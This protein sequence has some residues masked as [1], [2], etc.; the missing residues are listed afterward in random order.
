M[1]KTTLRSPI[2]PGTT[3]L[4]GLSRP[5]R[6]KKSDSVKYPTL[7]TCDTD[8]LTRNYHVVGNSRGI[9][10]IS[11]N[12]RHTIAGTSASRT[13]RTVSTTRP[14]VIVDVTTCVTTCNRKEQGEI[15]WSGDNCAEFSLKIT[16]SV[17]STEETLD[18]VDTLL[19]HSHEAA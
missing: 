8:Q 16:S 13:N 15:V 14:G 3:T 10:S 6:F 9:N 19:D 5:N 4:A 17:L 1:R 12:S 11:F 18:E 7:A 2:P